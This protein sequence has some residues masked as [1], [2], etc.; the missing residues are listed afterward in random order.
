MTIT[1]KQAERERF[2]FEVWAQEELGFTGQWMGARYGCDKMQAAWIGYKR[3]AALEAAE[4]ARDAAMPASFAEYVTREIPPGTVISNPAW[5]AARLW[6]AAQS[7]TPSSAEQPANTWRCFHCDEVFT[8]REQAAFHFGID[9]MCTPACGLD[10]GLVEA[11]RRQELELR[12]YRDEDSDKDR[13]M[14]RQRN[15]HVQ[16]L[17]RAEE[18]GYAKALKDTNYQEPAPSAPAADHS[19]DAGNMV[20]GGKDGA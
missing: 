4:A 11:Y 20:T 8:D 12:R 19:P 9:E 13:E 16:A 7:A 14:Y 17:Q 5:W 1:D 18:A 2:E 3:R 6:R 15:E 10:R